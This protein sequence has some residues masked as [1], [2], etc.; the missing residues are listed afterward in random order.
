MDR[1]VIFTLEDIPAQSAT[2]GA[3]GKRKLVSVRV[4]IE[5]LLPML[6]R[7]QKVVCVGGMGNG[8]GKTLQV[9]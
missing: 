8:C 3:L 2:A 1:F 6:S 4:R 5:T 7:N 9:I